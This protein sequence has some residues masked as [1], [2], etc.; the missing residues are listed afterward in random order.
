AIDYLI[1]DRWENPPG[2]EHYAVEKLVRLSDGYVCWAVPS[3]AP[4][5]GPLPATAPGVVTFGC[6]NNLAKI[7]PAVIA[8]WARLLQALP[9]ARLLLKTGA[10]A[11]A[12]VR[13]RILALFAAEG[14]PA[15]QID[16]EAGSPHSELL[17]RY[18]DIDIALDPFPYS[19]GLTTIEALWMGVPVVTMPG[20]RFASRHSFSHLNNVG[21]GDLVADSPEAYVRIAIEL[22]DDLPRL[23][24]LR[25]GMRERLATSPLLHAG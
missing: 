17:K 24:G 8:L 25:A 1:T 12:A 23:A 19:G 21:L 3:H 7:N 16:L 18:N 4:A 13:E 5:I 6:F 11:D 14:I 22:A 2:S 9:T 20:E 15:A 10:L